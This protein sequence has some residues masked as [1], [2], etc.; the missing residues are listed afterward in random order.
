MHAA[1]GTPTA[2]PMMVSLT[3]VVACLA[4]YPPPSS[5]DGMTAATSVARRCD[6]DGKDSGPDADCPAA[7]GNSADGE[8]ADTAAV[9]SSG[10][11]LA[12]LVAMRDEM[13]Q[14][15][16]QMRRE[17][18]EA[19][20]EGGASAAAK[21]SE[22]QPIVDTWQSPS[23]VQSI[24][25]AMSEHRQQRANGYLQDLERS[26]D[27][28]SGLLQA[29]G[30]GPLSIDLKYGVDMLLLSAKHT[31]VAALELDSSSVARM[32]SMADSANEALSARARRWRHILNRLQKTSSMLHVLVNSGRVTAEHGG[33]FPLTATDVAELAN[34]ICA[35]Y[36]SLQ[37]E[38]Q[39]D[40]ASLNQ[41]AADIA[42][43]MPFCSS[44]AERKA[45]VPFGM[46]VPAGGELLSNLP[47]ISTVSR[48]SSKLVSEDASVPLV[49][50]AVRTHK[51]WPTLV[52]TV[53]LYES[54]E[55]RHRVD[56]L[57]LRLSEAA[58]EAHS[59]FLQ[60]DKACE[61]NPDPACDDNDEFFHW[62]G[63]A[64]AAG[65]RLPLRTRDIAYFK[66]LAIGACL[67]HLQAHRRPE[68]SLED[69]GWP[70][71][72]QFQLWAAV[73]GGEKAQGAAGH[74]EHT[75]ANAICSGALYVS[76]P[77][78]T[79]TSPIIFSDPR[80]SWALS[81]EGG[82][83]R[84]TMLFTGSS[85]GQPLAPFHQ[86]YQLVPQAGELVIFPSWLM[87]SVQPQQ[88]KETRIAYSFNVVGKTF[89]DAWARTAV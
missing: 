64:S 77:R 35:A 9:T 80:G 20:Q 85:P 13:R 74:G 89:M 48:L 53:N 16:R 41:P 34:Q 60:T 44:S 62:Q 54:A 81:R 15:W 7:R 14:E 29:A 28:V 6:G 45:H 19:V 72:E 69:L 83:W 25:S 4:L 10:A 11:L 56:G 27:A 5:A 52:S 84:P 59:A 23:D 65:Q 66:Q 86:Q 58:Q 67:A 55:S 32:K 40:F 78:N 79:S 76:V 71:G 43:R 73:L 38:L 51:L 87:H 63:G 57:L 39:S 22:S 36:P 18:R 24:L 12:E 17:I 46:A 68:I 47:T 42:T 1:C 30:P 70:D 61:S 33:H 8:E 2:L 50:P 3:A 88:G 49:M 31:A 37:P 75:H 82:P 26:M 21:C